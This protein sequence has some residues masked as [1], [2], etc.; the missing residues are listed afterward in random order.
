MAKNKKYSIHHRT[1]QRPRVW[2]VAA[3]QTAPHSHYSPS[4]SLWGSSSEVAETP[5]GQVAELSCCFW[6]QDFQ[7]AHTYCTFVTWKGRGVW[8]DCS[9]IPLWLHSSA[10][11][12]HSSRPTAQ[13]PIARYLWVQSRFIV[14]EQLIL[15][16]TALYSEL[17]LLTQVWQASCSLGGKSLNKR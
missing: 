5:C 15:S 8:N 17:V 11:N 6:S 12:K 10:C 2:S 9:W 7:V 13:P 1:N 4:S 14:L 3:Y 16:M